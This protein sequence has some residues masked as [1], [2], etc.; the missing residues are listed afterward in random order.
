MFDRLAIIFQSFLVHGT[1]SI[2][3]LSCAFLP[4]FKSGLK[5]PEKVDSYRAIAS[6]SQLLKLF[7]NVILLVWGC[8]LGSDSLQFGYK[9]GTSSTQCSWLVTEVVDFYRKRGTAVR[10][11]LLDCSKAFDKFR[12]DQIFAKLLDRQL[13]A[14]VIRAMIFIY[15][16]QTA[17]VKITDK[18]SSI[19]NISNGTRQGSVASPA[20][21]AVYLDSLLQQLQ[22]LGLGC[23]V[24]GIWMGADQ[25]CDDLILLA[26][27]RS[28]LQKMVRVCE[29][30]VIDHNMVYSTDPN[31]ARRLNVCISVAEKEM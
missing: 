30:Y 6:S 8:L 2:Q 13:P 10:A 7:D 28:I 17:C 18:H 9:A 5:N 29:Q 24:G 3:L 12:F 11:C 27:T 1:V 25:F 22:Q 20:V 21:F 16:E 31:P 15:E 26:P 19:F 14:V 23:Q 4:L